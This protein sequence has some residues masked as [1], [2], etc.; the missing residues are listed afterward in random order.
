MSLE[1]IDND[2]SNFKLN[3]INNA[4]KLGEPVL[5]SDYISFSSVREPH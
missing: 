1:E 4:K 3:S 5:Y 2:Y